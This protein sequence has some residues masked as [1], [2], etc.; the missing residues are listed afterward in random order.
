MLDWV[1]AFAGMTKMGVMRTRD[2]GLKY[3]CGANGIA[4]TWAGNGL[5]R[6]IRLTFVPG[7]A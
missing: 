5:P 7:F 3:R 4:T 6:T 1:P 2:Y